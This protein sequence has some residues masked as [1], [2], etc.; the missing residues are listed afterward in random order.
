[1]KK[2]TGIK[3]G[4]LFLLLL[5]ILSPLTLA[6]TI[7]ESPNSIYLTGQSFYLYFNV[8]NDSTI[9]DNKTTQCSFNLFDDS[10]HILKTQTLPYAANYFYYNSTPLNKSNY[11]YSIFCNNTA[12]AGFLN[13]NFKVSYNIDPPQGLGFYWV[14]ILLPMFLSIICLIGAFLFPVET[15]LPLRV[16]LFLLAFIPL[17]VSIH[18]AVVGLV[19]FFNLQEM[20]NNLSSSVYYLGTILIVLVV[21]WFYYAII[22][23]VNIAAQNERDKYE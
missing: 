3:K 5:F 2:I 19:H 12:S 1:M 22:V 13:G 15:H 4:V 10:N 21:Y 6:L 20:V 8:Y 23:S 18:Y 14:I 17:F 9:Y 11:G 7:K 16:G